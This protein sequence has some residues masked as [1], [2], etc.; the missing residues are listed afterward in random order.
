MFCNG[1]FSLFRLPNSADLSSFLCIFLLGSFPVVFSTIV[2]DFDFDWLV[3]VLVG[4]EK[5]NKQEWQCG[6]GLT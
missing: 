3:S 2:I 1:G 4:C 5:C 6:G